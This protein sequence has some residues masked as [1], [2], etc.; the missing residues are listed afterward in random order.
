MMLNIH[1]GYRNVPGI[2]H[3]ISS[4]ILMHEKFH[5]DDNDDDHEHDDDDNDDGDAR[6]KETLL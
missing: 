2:P 4:P 6:A 5:Y 3:L 1:N